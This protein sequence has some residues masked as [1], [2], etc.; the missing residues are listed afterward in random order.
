MGDRKGVSGLEKFTVVAINHIGIVVRD[1]EK[2]VERYWRV[3]GI[4]PW[5]IFTF[6]PNARITTVR[7]EP[8]SFALRIAKAQVGS[9]QIELMQPLDGATPHQEFLDQRGEGVQH[10][11]IAVET[12]D[13]ASEIMS[14]LGFRELTAAYGVGVKGDGGAVY[15]DTEEVLGIS[16][17]LC[18]YPSERF[19]I[20]SVFPDPGT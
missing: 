6:G 1:L 13:Q 4:G 18:E 19:P 9:L 12:L 8:C 20:E 2:A 16:L 17:E 10:L 5:Q 15:F 3:L 7:G 11:G 14:M